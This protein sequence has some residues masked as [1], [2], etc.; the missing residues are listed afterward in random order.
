M[1]GTLSED[2]WLRWAVRAAVIVLIFG[3]GAYLVKGADTTQRPK[4]ETNGATASRVSGF[5]QIAFT[6]RSAGGVTTK[7]C[8]LLALTVAQ[9]DQGLMNRTNLAGY[10]G[11]IFR[12]VEPTTVEFYMKDTVIPLSIAWFDASGHFVSSTDM[13]P[14]PTQ[15]NCPLYAAANAYTDALEVPRGQLGQLGV[16]TGSVLSVGGAC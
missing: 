4:V 2:R 14:C 12:F 8:A 5:Q 11:M 7:H 16:G 13:A 3:V 6:V 1:I 15:D 10:N 9:Q